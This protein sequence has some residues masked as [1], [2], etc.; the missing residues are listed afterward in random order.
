MDIYII[1]GQLQLSSSI[2][3]FFAF[4]FT[5]LASLFFLSFLPMKRQ[6]QA[7]EREKK[8][9]N[10]KRKKMKKEE[11]ENKEKNQSEKKRKE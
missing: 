8:M 7:G 5:H 2:F 11:N 1:L 3:L 10:K 9:A 4:F 6:D